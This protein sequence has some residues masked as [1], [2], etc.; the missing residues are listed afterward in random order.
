VVG[1]WPAPF[2]TGWEGHAPAVAVECEGGGPACGTVTAALE[3]EGVK[4]AA[5]AGGQGGA[6][7]K[8]G[9]SSGS[10]AAP[11]GA[12]RVLVGPWSQLRSDPVAALVE[13]GPG[14]SGVYANFEE[15][16][17]TWQ[18]IGLDENG[19]KARTF[20]AGV[21]MVAATRR[22]EGPPVWLVT[23]GTGGAVRAAAGAL[24]AADLRDHFAVA[25]EAG[26]VTP[27]PLRSG[28]R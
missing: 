6:G 2:T 5:G 26:S 4:V 22:Y 28:S 7:S 1:S 23:G 3:H 12:I 10:G 9:A 16:H 15:V 14:E 18:L 27:L 21:G 13:R 20:G 25:S 24:D 17:G 11:K 8:S 19:N